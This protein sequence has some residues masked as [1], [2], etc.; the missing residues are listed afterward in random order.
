MIGLRTLRGRLLL[1]LFSA[2]LVAQALTFAVVLAERGQVMRGVMVDY[3]A[4]DLAS[5]VAMLDR[6]PA[7]ERGAWLPRLERAHY[8]LALA[9]PAIGTGAAR[10]ADTAFATGLSSA[11][12]RAL[13]ASG[14]GSSAVS[15][16]APDAGGLRVDLHLQDGTP[17]SVHILGAGMPLSNWMLAALIVQGLA[18]AVVCAVAVRGVTGP[19][20]RLASAAQAWRPDRMARLAETGPREVVQ[21][22][23]AFN[24]MN[25]RISAQL[26]ERNHML[27]AIA[28]DLQTP[29]TRMGLR[30]DLLTD[31]V[32]RGRLQGDLDQMQ[33]LVGQGLAYARSAQA[34]DETPL[35]VDIEALVQSIVDDYQDAGRPVRGPAGSDARV[36]PPPE[37]VLWTRPRALRRALENLIDN[38][39]KF[40]GAAEV[41]LEVGTGADAQARVTLRVLDR[42]PGIPPAEL[43]R[44]TRPFQRLTP[45]RDP[46]VGGHGLGL[47]I[48]E[49]LMAPCA[50]SLVIG[51][52]EG[53][54]LEAT[55]RLRGLSPEGRPGP[56]EA[57]A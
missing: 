35:S 40:A 52:R 14:G 12:A 19:L 22:A 16:R 34:A 49:R 11:L 9:E 48:V 8:R 31:P 38:A 41:R 17:L 39:L 56:G 21:A 29:I 6:L 43:A 27:G 37:Q 26:E 36:P 1:I 42:G 13:P 57:R 28:H 7:A 18:L 33:H 30:T 20:E 3:V 15:V 32:L 54:G 25:E 24:R 50:A 45:A 53:G 10:G 5:S 4:A 44:V 2:L 46:E 51:P 55:V 47:A 23:A